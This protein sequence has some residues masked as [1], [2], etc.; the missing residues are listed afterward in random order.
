LIH[1]DPPAAEV[2]ARI[3]RRFGT[4]RSLDE[5][6]T[7]FRQAFAR[8]EEHDRTTGLRTSEMREVERWRN[9]VASVLDD[10]TDSDDCFHELFEHFARPDAWRCEPHAGRLLEALASRRYGLAIASNYDR[11][12]YGVVAA[13]PALAGVGRIVISSEVGWRKPAPEFFDALCRSLDLPAEE[14]LH[15]GDDFVNDYAGA[16]AAGLEALLVGTLQAGAHTVANL[17]ALL[18]LLGSGS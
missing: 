14:V 9:I 8:E 13:T 16:R 2:Y 4:R 1:P 15:V 10:V 11:R 7:R 3:G 6:R 17:S 5:I 12:L 18:D